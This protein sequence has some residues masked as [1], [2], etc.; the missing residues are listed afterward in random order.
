[1]TIAMGL[2]SCNDE[3]KDEQF[4]QMASFKAEQN[5]QGVTWAY[6]RYNPQ[7]KVRFDLPVVISGSTPNMQNRTIHIG[8]DS[9]TLAILNHE[10]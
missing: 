6:L 1:M 7:G 5:A 9:D 2:V 8:L 4:V 3:W 10:Q